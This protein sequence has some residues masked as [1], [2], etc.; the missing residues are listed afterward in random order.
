MD[1]VHNR[2]RPEAGLDPVASGSGL[3][4]VDADHFLGM[5]LQSRH[6][7]GV[8]SVAAG[9][10]N[11]AL[12]RLITHV[13]PGCVC[14]DDAADSLAILFQFHH[15][16]FIVDLQTFCHSIIEHLVHGELLIILGGVLSRVSHIQKFIIG[17][18]RVIIN[19]MAEFHAALS[20]TVSEPVDGLSAVVRP[21]L[22]KAAAGVTLAPVAEVVDRCGLIHIVPVFLLLAGTAGCKCV[23]DAARHIMGEALDQDGPDPFLRCRRGRKGTGSARADDQH[24]T[25]ILG[26]NL[27]FRDHGL[28]AEPVIVRCRCA[29][30][31]NDHFRTG[32]LGNAGRSRLPNGRAGRAGSRDGIDFV[33]LRVQDSLLHGLADGRADAGGLSGHIDLDVGNRIRVKGHRDRDFTLH[34]PCRCAVSARGVHTGSSFDPF[35]VQTCSEQCNPGRSGK[36]SPQ[37]LT[38]G[39]FI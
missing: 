37:K 4:E 5:R 11:H 30:V 3:V 29:V 13:L 14:R 19:L 18:K 10:D 38:T 39:K 24:V 23:A 2:S 34:A 36:R 32:S 35:C 16:G 8:H 28:F 31:F 20:Q 22:G 12:C 1:R 9:G 27:V 6:H 21:E 25:L 7:I 26:R 33:T 17:G 15:C